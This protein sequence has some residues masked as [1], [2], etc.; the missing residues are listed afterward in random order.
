MR[1]IVALS[2]LLSAPA[3]LAHSWYPKDCC[4]GEDCVPVNSIEKIPGKPYQIWHTDKF[5]PVQVDDTVMKDRSRVSED[6]GYHIC[7]VPSE[8]TGKERD[9][10]LSQKKPPSLDRWHVQCVFIPGTA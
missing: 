1:G 3:A 8:Q 4:H 10:P 9:L 5:G 7:A 2:I 6:G